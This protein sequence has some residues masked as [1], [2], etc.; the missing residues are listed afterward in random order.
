MKFED[1]GKEINIGGK[2]VGPVIFRYDGDN[3]DFYF[4]EG[5]SLLGKLKQFMQ[6]SEITQLESN[7]VR[8]SDGAVISASSIFGED[9]QSD[10]DE[11]KV[12]STPEVDS[13]SGKDQCLGFI[14][15]ITSATQKFL[16]LNVK[17]PDVS[18]GINTKMYTD[19][20]AD[21]FYAENGVLIPEYYGFQYNYFKEYDD[22]DIPDSST[23]EI[24]YRT[25]KSYI[26]TPNA[27]SVF[28]GVGVYTETRTQTSRWWTEWWEGSYPGAALCISTDHKRG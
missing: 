5:R 17:E 26:T 9:L 12:L 8:L 25:D 15:R 4:S 22:M 20:N 28:P 14:V 18:V 7:P 24:G 27:T 11:I 2:E 21:D 1:D 3:S 19:Y 16:K 13:S 23:G 6:L 10:V